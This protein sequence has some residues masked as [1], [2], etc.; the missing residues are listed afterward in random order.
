MCSVNYRS[1]FESQR[2]QCTWRVAILL[3][4]GHRLVVEVLLDSGGDDGE[5]DATGEADTDEDQQLDVQTDHGAAVE[6]ERCRHTVDEVEECHSL[7]A[8]VGVHSLEEGVYLGGEASVA[9]TDHHR[10]QHRQPDIAWYISFVVCVSEICRVWQVEEWNQVAQSLYD[11]PDTYDVHPSP[12][13]L[14]E[15]SAFQDQHWTS[16]ELSETYGNAHERDE[17]L[18]VVT[19]ALGEPDTGRVDAGVVGHLETEV[20]EQRTQH[21]DLGFDCETE[22]LEERLLGPRLRDEGDS[23]RPERRLVPLL[24]LVFRLLQEQHEERCDGRDTEQRD[25]H[26]VSCLVVDLGLAFEHQEDEDVAE[27][28]RAFEQ[29]PEYARVA[30]DGLG[31]RVE[32]GVVA[33]R[34][35]QQRRATAV[36]YRSA[37]HQP[38]LAQVERRDEGTISER[39]DGKCRTG[40][41]HADD[42]RRDPQEDAEEEVQDAQRDVPVCRKRGVVLLRAGQERF[43]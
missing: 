5:A 37:V 9:D 8:V 40:T 39:A 13:I 27:K 21:E 18:A 34:G 11:E 43:L 16:D 2:V 3:V 6:T 41:D 10:T 4:C 19:E 32:D 38:R 7:W 22:R 36:H 14:G 20:A 15:M 28:Q 24:A 25:D 12:L 23:R 17:L 30:R 33:L 1:V 26:R 31:P 35:P 42:A 29:D